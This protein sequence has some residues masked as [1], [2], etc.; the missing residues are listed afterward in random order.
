MAGNHLRWLRAENLRASSISN[1]YGWL[2]S[3]PNRTGTSDFRSW[4]N[5]GLKVIRKALPYTM[6][7]D[8]KKKNQLSHS[9]LLT[10]T[11]HQTL[12]Q[13]SPARQHRARQRFHSYSE[14]SVVVVDSLAIFRRFNGMMVQNYYFLISRGI[15]AGKKKNEDQ[16]RCIM[17]RSTSSGPLLSTPGC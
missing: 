10:C 9:L 15:W 4:R 6:E 13:S 3:S 5:H 8:V 1:E 7:V 14:P 2:P 11:Y 17:R 16:C 12:R